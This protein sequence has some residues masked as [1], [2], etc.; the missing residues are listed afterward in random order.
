MHIV[1][2]T[3]VLVSGVFWS[4]SSHT[5]LELWAKGELGFIVSEAILKEYGR[6]MDVVS[7]QRAESTLGDK[8]ATFIAQNAVVVDAPRIS[9]ECRD[10][11]DDKCAVAGRASYLVSGDRDLLRLKK[12]F[13]I[14]IVSP[15][16][17]LNLL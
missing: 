8:W 4:G 6:V 3:N 10:P 12:A 2:D 11:D 9:S 13:G 1:L 14:P 16:H 5:I 17:F 7:A 15:S